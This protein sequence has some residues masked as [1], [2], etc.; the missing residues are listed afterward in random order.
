MKLF[1]LSFILLSTVQITK[2][3][4]SQVNALPQGRYETVIKS[5]VNKWEKGDIILLD[6]NNY[7]IS[8]DSDMGQYRFSI[9]AQRIFFT[10]GPLKG[11][12][13][14]VIRNNNAPVIIIPLVENQQIGMKPATADIMG[15]HKN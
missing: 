5:S 12:Y 6:E 1:L 14:K 13:A 2:A 4:D 7:K 10:S 9:T 11:I 3:Q 8:S 15:Y